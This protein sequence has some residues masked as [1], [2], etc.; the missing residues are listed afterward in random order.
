MNE[1]TSVREEWDTDA[2]RRDF[3][4]IGFLAPYVAVRRKADGVVGSLQFTHSPRVYFG[5]VADTAQVIA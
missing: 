3:E 2:L 5:F 1:S 4:V